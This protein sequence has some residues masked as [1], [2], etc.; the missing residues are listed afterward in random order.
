MVSPFEGGW[1]NVI[2]LREKIRVMFVVGKQ[3][4]TQPYEKRVIK[5]TNF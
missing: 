5:C 2:K 4:Q 3:N 1:G